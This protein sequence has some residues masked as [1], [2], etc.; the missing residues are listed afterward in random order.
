MQLVLDS[1]NLHLTKEG[2]AFAIKSEK[3]KRIIAPSKLSSIAITSNV[4]FNANAVVLAIKHEIPI[5][6]FDRIGKAKARLWSPYFESIATLRRQ[7]IRFAESTNASSWMIDLFRLKTLGQISNLQHLKRHSPF[8]INALQKAV[9]EINRQQKQ[10]EPYREQ[11]LEECSNNIMG[12]EGIIARIYWQ[13]LGSALPRKY[14]FTKRTRRPAEDLFNA[15]LNY[16]YGM[17]YS[18]VE[19]AIFSV[20]LDPYLGFLHK[21]E[22]RKPTLAFDLIEPFRPKID[23]LVIDACLKNEIIPSFFTSNQYGIFLNKNGKAYLIPL[24][25]DYL[26]S[27]EKWLNRESTV[28]NHI[29]HIAG[30]L[31]QRIRSFDN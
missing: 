22:Y 16:C 25:N 27:T 11:L 2:N 26:R 1:K 14:A 4:T 5:L 30:V 21:D 20:G 31:A 15:T 6:F 17:L 19:S 3:G 12:N 8:S 9:T 29:Y 18:V 7:Q 13:T 23:R 24:F 10:L 28:K